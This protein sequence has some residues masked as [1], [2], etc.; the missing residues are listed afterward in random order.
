M[1]FTVLEDFWSDETKSQYC[2]G[3][4]YTAADER[5]RKLAEQWIAEGKAE[6][7]GP[8]AELTGRG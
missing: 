3:L 2:A 8:A 1:Q 5:L 6:P 7:G 4:S